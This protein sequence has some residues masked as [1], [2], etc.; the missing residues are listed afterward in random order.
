M[1]HHLIVLGSL[2]EAFMTSVSEA[3]VKNVVV[4]LM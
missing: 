3:K 4:L 1:G 2:V